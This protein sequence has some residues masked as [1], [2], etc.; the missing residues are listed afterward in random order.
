MIVEVPEQN[1]GI[2]FQVEGARRTSAGGAGIVP[3]IRRIIAGLVFS[4]ALLQ[5]SVANAQAI[6]QGFAGIVPGSNDYT[7]QVAYANP[8]DA[9]ASFQNSFVPRFG[10]QVYG[11]IS[12]NPYPDQIDYN[13]GALVPAYGCFMDAGPNN[14]A[15]TIISLMGCSDPATKWVGG[16]CIPSTYPVTAEPCDCPVAK[17]T[18]GQF[19]SLGDPVSVSSGAKT[20]VVTDYSSGGP[21]PIEI[22]RYYRSMMMPENPRVP[23]IGLAW[24]LNLTGR[25]LDIINSQLVLVSRDDGQQ[26]R[27]GDYVG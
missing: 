24:R 20:E 18:N 9:C 27:F 15:N 6:A 5:G 16:A 11:V 8:A 3:S 25:H 26:S 19:P 12:V 22:K 13:T 10:Y 2:A 7:H 14:P 4:L 17:G 21:Y 23:G 1:S